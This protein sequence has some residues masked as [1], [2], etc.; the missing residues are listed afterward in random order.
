MNVV[1]G[2]GYIKGLSDF[3]WSQLMYDL[4]HKMG[5]VDMSENHVVLIHNNNNQVIAGAVFM[6][7]WGGLS[8]DRIFFIQE[9]KDNKKLHETMMSV[10]FE[11]AK[12]L[13]CSFIFTDFY[14]DDHDMLIML[15]YGFEIDSR[16]LV[17]DDYYKYLVV[18]KQFSQSNLKQFYDIKYVEDS[19]EIYMKYFAV[20]DNAMNYEI[21]SIAVRDKKDI[22]LG[23]AIIRIKL[24]ES[25]IDSIAV[26][27]EYQG[28]G[29][30]GILMKYIDKINKENNISRQTLQTLSCQAMPFYK[31]YGFVVQYERKGY[32]NDLSQYFMITK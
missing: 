25:N 1:T 2:K 21:Y 5:F 7:Y 26:S 8:V 3:I 28:R 22:T 32:I 16:R 17:K 18:C 6:R 27:H 23:G 10:L 13:G 9:E 11:Q 12:I 29:I 20:H 30:G 19:Y 24:G 31:K 15:E 14:S 4:N